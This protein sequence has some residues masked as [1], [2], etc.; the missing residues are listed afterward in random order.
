[1]FLPQTGSGLLNP[2][3]RG[4]K[5]T[6]SRIRN[7]AFYFI[8]HRYCDHLAKVY[9]ACVYLLLLGLLLGLDLLLTA[10]HFVCVLF[11]DVGIDQILF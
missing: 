9:C 5:C 4:K 10:R 8:C 7:T 2:G 6:G 1:M 11:G 3:S